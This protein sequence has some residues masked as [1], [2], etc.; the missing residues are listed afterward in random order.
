MEDT[1]CL[2]FLFYELSKFYMCIY[3]SCRKYND[4]Y[5]LKSQW[6]KEYN[7]II[8]LSSLTFHPSDI[9]LLISFLAEAPGV[10]QIMDQEQ[11]GPPEKIA[12]RSPSISNQ[13]Y[14]FLTK[15]AVITTAITAIFL[16]N[17]GCLARATLSFSYLLFPLP[18][19][20]PI[21]L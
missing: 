15:S 12:F 1:H 16:F 14:I 9:V 21:P 5:L 11:P 19:A 17:I 6:G 8:A 2:T 13:D 7:N 3:F 10:N 4:I 18:F 20:A